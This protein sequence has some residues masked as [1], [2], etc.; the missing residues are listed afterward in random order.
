MNKKGF[1]M[2]LLTGVVI[3]LVVFSFNV[4]ARQVRWGRE[5]SPNEKI[6]EIF[7]I[8]SRY[9]IFEYDRDVMLENMYRGLVAGI[10]DPYSQYY[11]LESRS[12][13][14]ERITGE[15]VGIGVRV[16]MD[17]VERMLGIVQVFNDS[18][19]F[20]AGLQ[21]GDKFATVDGVNVI[22]RSA[23]EILDKVRGVAGTNVTIEFLRPSENRRF[24]VTITRA[25]IIVPSVFH[26]LIETEDGRTG[27]IRIEAFERPTTSQFEAALAELMS[28]SICSLIIDVRN[29]PGGLMD[30]VASITN[31]LVPEG[32]ITFTEDVNGRRRYHRA[33]A[34][35]LGLPL[36]VLVNGNSAS[37]SEVL[38]G[39]VLDTG[40]G[41]IVGEQTFGKGSVQTDF[42]LSDGTA[43][44]L[45][46]AKYFT[47]NGNSIH[48]VG[49]TPNFVVEMDESYSHRV[50]HDLGLEED[51]QL[52]VALRVLAHKE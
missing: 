5:L 46:I 48:G 34:N 33:T 15:F 26:D 21:P 29:N 18:P 35:Y 17:P 10:G 51:V 27:Y 44:K 45:T 2:G 40:A 42:D 41:T 13:F 14:M 50:G 47:P 11:C 19:A 22:G 8:V 39:A 23:D 43:I 31:A 7:S 52:Q 30:V 25:Q 16:L 12:R 38:A 36:V 24:E 3:M 9:S 32:I 37:A 20:H 6:S 1:I 4:Y 28:Q 49:L